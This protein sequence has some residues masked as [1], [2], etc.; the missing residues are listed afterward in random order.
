[1]F[2]CKDENIAND[3]DNHSAERTDGTEDSSETNEPGP[4]SPV[5]ENHEETETTHGDQ[6]LWVKPPVEL[7]TEQ[8]KE[9]IQDVQDCEYKP[10]VDIKDEVEESEIIED[11]IIVEPIIR[12]EPI[13]PPVEVSLPKFPIPKIKPIYPRTQIKKPRGRTGRKPR[14]IL[15]MTRPIAPA[16][17]SHLEQTS[18]PHQTPLQASHQTPHQ[19][20]HQIIMPS[21]HMSGIAYQIFLGDHT[22]NTNNVQYTMLQPQQVFLQQTPTAVSTPS[23]VVI[24]QPSMVINTPYQMRERKTIQPAK[25]APKIVKQSYCTFCYKHFKNVNEHIKDC[26]LNPDSKNYKFRKIAPSTPL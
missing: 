25:I 16:S 19:T 9:E 15:P 20:P 12:C 7:F 4:K 23:P 13:E 5:P 10:I 26:G 3:F 2:S 24:S 18:V 6:R 8:I 17:S 21:P 14:P 11:E 1:M 22:K